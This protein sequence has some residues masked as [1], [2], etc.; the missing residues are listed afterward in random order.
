MNKELEEKAIARLKAFE[1][2]TEPYYLAYSGGKDSDAI[3]ILAELSGVKYKTYHTL[4][5]VDAPETVHYVKSQPDI[6]I[7]RNYWDAEK[8]KPITMWNLIPQKK[9]PPT[10]LA[11][12][13]CKELKEYAGKGRK[14][15]TGV[16]WAESV[17]RAQ[18]SAVA[19]IM[20]NSQKVKKRAEEIGVDFEE[21][22]R[23]GIILNNDNSEARQMV[24][25]C[26]K[27]HKTTINP[28]VD[29]TDRDVWEFLRHY[30]CRSNPLYECGYHRIGCVGCPMADKDR[31]REFERYPKYKENYIKAFDRMLKTTKSTKFTWNTGEDVFRWWMGEDL[32]QLRFEDLEAIKELQEEY[33]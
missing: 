11:R 9:M 5:S 24:E 21:T 22:D 19:I 30:G 26:Y 8:T 4:T 25:Q 7:I 29:W 31:Y 13:C 27:Q 2:Q 3:K 17:K 18:N 1:P 33:E 12:Y 14:V 23:K 6:E 10:R 28:I 15:I 20:N 16:R 32:S